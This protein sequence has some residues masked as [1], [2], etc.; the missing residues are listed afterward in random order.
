VLSLLGAI[1][2]SFIHMIRKFLQNGDNAYLIAICMSVGYWVSGLFN[3]SFWSAWWQ[4][5]FVLIIALC[6]SQKS[7][8][9]LS[10]LENARL[11]P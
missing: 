2:V 1:A 5:S 10:N 6:L 3:F 8:A 7:D 11:R 9:D 4:M